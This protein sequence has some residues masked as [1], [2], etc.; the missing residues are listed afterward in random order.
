MQQ[1]G[2]EEQEMLQSVAYS[3]KVMH[4]LV[5]TNMM[6]NSQWALINAV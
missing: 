4:F 6:A 3:M 1:A 5:D 2:E